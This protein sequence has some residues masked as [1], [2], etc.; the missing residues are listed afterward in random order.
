M[1]KQYLVM[2]HEGIGCS[3]NATGRGIVVFG[4]RLI[5]ATIAR[6]KLVPSAISRET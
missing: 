2:Q 6:M 1:A 4:Q 5:G 3:E